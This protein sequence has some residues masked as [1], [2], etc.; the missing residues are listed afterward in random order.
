MDTE[1]L[2]FLELFDIGDCLL[3][4]CEDFERKPDILSPLLCLVIFD[5]I[6]FS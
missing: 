5:L 4:V 6:G 2:L 3:K 1:A